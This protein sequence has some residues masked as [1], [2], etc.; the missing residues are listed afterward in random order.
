MNEYRKIGILGGMGPEATEE[1]YSR[2]T[3]IFQEEYGAVYDADFPE[4]IIINLPIPDVVED[5]NNEA[6][7]KEMMI[8]RIKKLQSCGADFVVV[9]CNA[10]TYYLPPI[11]E[12][13]P[14][15]ILNPPEET[16]KVV[17]KMGIDKVGL[18][19]TEMTI[20]RNIYKDFIED[21]EII[22][23][24][25][26]ERERITEIIMNILAG[27]KEKKDKNSL[28]RIIQNLRSRG[29]EKVILGCTDLPLLLETKE[30]TLDT[31][32]ILAEA[33]VRESIK[34]GD[35]FEGCGLGK[36]KTGKL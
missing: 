20:R 7:I 12:S 33:T 15:P 14:V 27:T 35:S 34:E 19:G 10:V 28:S 25:K 31:L 23:P 9:P 24:D 6:V 29:A 22:T 4:M 16:A 26:N 11:K 2:I 3:C 8:D 5:T 21:V 36:E 1:L 32:Q 13:S 30:S 18:L 17:K